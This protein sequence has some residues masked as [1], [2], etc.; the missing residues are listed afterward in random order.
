MTRHLLDGSPDLPR[1]PRAGVAL[2]RPALPV[3]LA[4]VA[5]RSAGAPHDRTKENSQSAPLRD[6]A[7]LQNDGKA[8]T[9]L[10]AGTLNG[11]IALISRGDC[12]FAVK[13][14]NAQKAGAV[15]VLIYQTDRVLPIAA[16]GLMNTGIPVAMVGKD[17]GASLKQYLVSNPDAVVVLDPAVDSGKV[18]KVI[19]GLQSD[20]A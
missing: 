15:A 13:V 9:A 4:H 8:C 17:D 16:G 10:G 20:G 7:R 1:C 19:R 14:N 12:S 18:M 11:A 3:L 2:V 6:V 5:L